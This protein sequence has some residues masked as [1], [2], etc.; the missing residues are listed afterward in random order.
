M[1]ASCRVHAYAADNEVLRDLLQPNAAS[2]G[3]DVAKGKRPSQ[4]LEIRHV[5]RLDVTCLA[6]M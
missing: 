1:S 2:H 4:S 6:F 5:Q 3:V